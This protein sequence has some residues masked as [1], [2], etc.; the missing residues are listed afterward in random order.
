MLNSALELKSRDKEILLEAR[1]RTNMHPPHG[2]IKR[3]KSPR[4]HCFFV[5]PPHLAPL[6]RPV[7]AN[8]LA[9]VL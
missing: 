9:A 7:R 8:R 1:G 2:E 3:K 6:Q 5:I 4:I